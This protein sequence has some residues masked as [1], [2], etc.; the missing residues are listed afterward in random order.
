MTIAETLAVGLIVLAATAYLVRRAV[1]TLRGRS[2]G[3]A[4][5]SRSEGCP[6]ASEMAARI[7]RMSTG[8]DR[9]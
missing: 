1:R 7:E 6:A 5:A 9:R 3:C 4:A 8:A 2:C